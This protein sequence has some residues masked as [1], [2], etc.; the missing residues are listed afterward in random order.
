MKVRVVLLL[1][2][3]SAYVCYSCIGSVAKCRTAKQLAHSFIYIDRNML[4]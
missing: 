1:A 2:A 4:T 3:S